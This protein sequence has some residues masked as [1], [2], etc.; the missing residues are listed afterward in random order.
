MALN[1]ANQI[2]GL[3]LSLFEVLSFMSDRKLRPYPTSVPRSHNV[4]CQLSMLI[5]PGDD[6]VAL[7]KKPGSKV[8]SLASM[9]TKTSTSTQM[10][11][12]H[13]GQVLNR[14]KFYIPQLTYTHRHIN[15]SSSVLKCFMT[16]LP[17]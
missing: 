7:P 16:E 9:G 12:S 6:D 15:Y 5:L 13:L 2:N 10:F 1:T 11:A 3:W 14:N 4:F 8:G 17:K